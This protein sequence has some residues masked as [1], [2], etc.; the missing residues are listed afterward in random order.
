MCCL[1]VTECKNAKGRVGAKDVEVW[2]NPRNTTFD[3]AKRIYNEKNICD[4]AVMIGNGM[5]MHCKLDKV[6]GTQHALIVKG[7]E[8]DT[9]MLMINVHLPTSWQAIKGLQD[10][11]ACIDEELHKH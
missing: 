2:F 10:A 7:R 9:K 11:M 6:A 1:T 8:R 3:G 4:T 5:A